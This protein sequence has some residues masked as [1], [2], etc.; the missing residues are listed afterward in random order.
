MGIAPEPES[1]LPCL[2]NAITLA[3]NLAEQAAG[4]ELETTALTLYGSLLD[5]AEGAAGRIAADDPTRDTAVALA[6]LATSIMQGRGVLAS[7][8]IT[9]EALDAARRRGMA[10]AEQDNHGRRRPVAAGHGNRRDGWPRQLQSV[11]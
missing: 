2:A 1:V 10:A 8:E 6:V 5:A 11:S 7:R 9:A 3:A 4:T